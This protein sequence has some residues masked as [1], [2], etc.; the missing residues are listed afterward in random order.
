MLLQVRTV[1]QR[2]NLCICK[3]H[4]ILLCLNGIFNLVQKFRRTVW[5]KVHKITS[6]VYLF[7]PQKKLWDLIKKKKKQIFM[8][9]V[10]LSYLGFFCL[11]TLKGYLKNSKCLYYSFSQWLKLISDSSLYP[12][13][14]SS[15]GHSILGR[16]K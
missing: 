13:D 11:D 2:K 10:R 12:L 4:K 6:L 16:L 9:L 14:S 15:Q 1:Q 5:I 7:F 8:L 3:A